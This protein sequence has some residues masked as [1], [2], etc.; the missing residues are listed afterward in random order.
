M[1]GNVIWFTGNTGAGKTTYALKAQQIS[2]NTILLD[3]DRC[4]EIWPGLTLTKKDREE[5]NLR[6][7]R[8]AK[9]LSDQGFCVLIAVICPYKEL[10]KKVQRICGCK[11]IYVTGG[12][13]ST[14]Q[15]PYQA[16]ND[17]FLKLEG[18]HDY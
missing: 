5:Q 9:Y 6:I 4:R 12:A 7:A 17:Y 3:G 8:L 15:T 10:R 14:E 1:A 18:N 16:P 11:F 2:V 13:P